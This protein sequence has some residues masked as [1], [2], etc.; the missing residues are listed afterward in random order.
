MVPPFPPPPTKYSVTIPFVLLLN[1]AAVWLPPD[2]ESLPPPITTL[3]LESE[4]A[5]VAPIPTIPVP[6]ILNTSSTLC[7]PIDNLLLVDPAPA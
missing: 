1:A 5:A 7:R 2:I 3:S 6:R 4:Y